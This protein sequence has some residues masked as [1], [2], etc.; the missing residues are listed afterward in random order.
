MSNVPKLRFK[1][2]GGKWEEKKLFALSENGFS[3][4]AFN[5]P[6]K[7]GSGYKIINVKD[8]Y[9][10]GTINTDYLTKVAL[11]EKEF[12]KNRVEYGDIFFTRSSLVKEG[13]AFSNI[14]LTTNEDLT[15]DGH[16]IRMRPRKEICSPIF[17][18]YNF[19]TKR[20][21]NQLIVRGKTTTMTTIG[22]EDIASVNISLPSKLEQEKIASFLTSVDTKI[23]QL[24]KK[25]SL[26]QE[27]KKGVMNKIFHQEI[28]FKDDDGSEFPEWEEKKLGE[29]GKFK[30][31]TGFSEIEQG[32][33]LGVPFY[34]VSDMNLL[35]N[36]E[37]MNISNN[38]VTEEQIERLKLK[39]IQEK[40]IIFAKVGAAIFLERK[41]LAENFLIDNNMM[42]FIPNENI[43]YIKQL[44]HKIK[45]SKYAQ[46]GAL[47]SYN[48]SDLEIIKISLPSLKEQ[49]KIAN[50]LSSIDKKIELTTKEL[51]SI[52]EFKKAL[53]QQMFV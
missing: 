9:I 10:D 1:E 45:L 34:K 19:A 2:F 22:Q 36:E 47:P 4:G 28:R 18:Y 27:Y 7:V 35:S 3:N 12:L 46:V 51:N 30:S 29:I 38:Y 32:G 49:I 42:A 39:V 14:N 8:M 53:L 13:I 52:K 37:Y 50:F 20:V 6:K 11:D 44:F 33:N 31:G 41:R 48:A 16:L 23:E 24:T 5:D 21:R 25:E 43:Y 40:A 17:L 15:F 26:L